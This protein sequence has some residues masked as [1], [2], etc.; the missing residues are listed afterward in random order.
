MPL[1]V[2]FETWLRAEA[3]R[4]SRTS[5][6]GKAVAHIPTRWEGPILSADDGRIEMDGNP[7]ENR[8][9]E[10]QGPVRWTDP[11]DERPLCGA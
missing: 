4:L 11:P 2:G 6:M 1:R 3:A 8:S 9:A 10:D 5:G 7:V